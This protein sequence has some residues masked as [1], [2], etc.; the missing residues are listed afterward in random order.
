[1]RRTSAG[2]VV[3]EAVN[4]RNVA[5]RGAE[6]CPVKAEHIQI[7][8]QHPPENTVGDDLADIIVSQI[9]TV[10]ENAAEN[11]RRYRTEACRS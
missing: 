11:D 2:E 7:R 10:L 3:I 1:M 9:K 6:V 5:G 4:V 8:G